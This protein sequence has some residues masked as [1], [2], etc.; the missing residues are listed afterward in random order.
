[1][2]KIET[3]IKERIAEIP[4]KDLEKL[5]IKAASM[6]KQFYDFLLL[7]HIDKEFGEEDLF[8][9]A[10]ADLKSLMNK[11]Y[12]GYSFELKMGNMISACNKRIND[13]DKVSK[14]KS[15]VLEL[16]LIVLDV[17]FSVDDDSLSTCFTQFNYRL[18]LLLKKAITIVQKKMHE[19]YHI[20]YSPTLN[21]YL[22]RLHNTCNYLDYI[23][24]LPES[25]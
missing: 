4:K 19:D 10:K 8:E 1:M 25:I 2:A 3:H 22:Q 7:N 5:V 6:N 24:D 14:D 20:Q 12:K 17:S 11:N 18:S 9:Q 15:K 16:I 13:F 21:G 23:Y